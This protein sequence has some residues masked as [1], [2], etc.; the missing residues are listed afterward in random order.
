MSPIL[1]VN[2]QSIVLVIS[3]FNMKIIERLLKGATSAFL[4]YK[5]IEKNLITFRVPGALEI[6][7]AIHQVLKYHSPDAIIAIGA[8]IRGE[9]PHFDYVAAESSR[10]LLKL[11]LNAEI[12]I[13]NCILTA[14]TLLQARERSGEN[15]KNKGWVAIESALQTI[16]TY[17][18]IQNSI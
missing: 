10:G 12:P 18:L 1:S 17:R 8:I 9:T 15:K 5:G 16:S 6:P 2:D 3:E 4:H 14:D 11:S 7:G 13:I